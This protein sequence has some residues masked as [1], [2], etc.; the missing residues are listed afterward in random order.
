M[1]SKT[2]GRYQFFKPDPTDLVDPHPDMQINFDILDKQIYD[3]TRY[4]VVN[5]IQ[6][7]PLSQ[8][9]LGSK[10]YDRRSGR[11]Y[12]YDLDGGIPYNEITSAN[13]LNLWSNLALNGAYASVAT[14][15]NECA[16]RWD[17]NSHDHVQLKGKFFLT[18]S[19]AIP[20]NVRTK[21]VDAGQLPV[22][23]GADRVFCIHP[24]MGVTNP[25]TIPNGGINA[26]IEIT[27]ST[28]ELWFT[29]TGNSVATADENIIVL[30]NI[31]YATN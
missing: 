5:R 10:V 4:Q 25:E 31:I 19:G 12:F 16:W 7:V 15:L 22:P 24:G 1:A 6:D 17:N 23:S 18:G 2:T 26:I 29:K 27:G 14:I 13:N 11:F 8:V 9:S 21:I 20:K 30:D 3:L 28:G